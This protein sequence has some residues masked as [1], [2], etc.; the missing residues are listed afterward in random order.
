MSNEIAVVVED[1]DWLM[2]FCS[3][4]MFSSV[5][6]PSLLAWPRTASLDR[7]RRPCIQDDASR[8]GHVSAVVTTGEQPVAANSRPAYG[9]IP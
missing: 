1:M 9:T 4:A 7:S 6:R 8:S 3:Q 5:T 2:L